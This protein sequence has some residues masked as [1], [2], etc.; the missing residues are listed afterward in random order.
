[1]SSRP[2]ELVGLDGDDTLWRNEEMF[3]DV[4][5]RL[6]EL[7]HTYTSEADVDERLIEL[8]RGNLALFGY[9]VKAFTLSMIETAIELT[10]GPSSGP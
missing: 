2:I 8:E 9:G 3:A 4:E 1:M 10:E 7:I 6:R 5:E